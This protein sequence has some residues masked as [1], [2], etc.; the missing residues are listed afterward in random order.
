MAG[1]SKTLGQQYKG[2]TVTLEGSPTGEAITTSKFSYNS[3]LMV[4]YIAEVKIGIL[5]SEPRH[6]INKMEYNPDTTLNRITTAQNILSTGA[7][8]V[9]VQILSPLEAK[10]IVS[11]D[12]NFLS[13]NEGDWFYINTPSNNKR[14]NV[15]GTNP[16]N[17]QEIIVQNMGFI[18]ETSTPITENIVNITLEHSLTKDYSRRIWDLRTRYFYS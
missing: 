4:E 5:D 9:S 14:V 12:G 10:I 15:I 17:L 11:L 2:L 6:Y 16:N 8:Q 13:V 1:D 7:S 18:S 3:L